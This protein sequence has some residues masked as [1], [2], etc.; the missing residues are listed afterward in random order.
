MI[1]ACMRPIY[2]LQCNNLVDELGNTPLH[3]AAKYGYLEIVKAIVEKG[4]NVKINIENKDK[5]SPVALAAKNRYTPVVDYLN[6]CG[7]KVG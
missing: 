7:L 2:Q 5:L 6:S 1:V 4:I 3:Y